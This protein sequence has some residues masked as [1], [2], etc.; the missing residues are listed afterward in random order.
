MKGYLRVVF[1]GVRLVIEN[2]HIS[3]QVCFLPCSSEKYIT[4]QLNLFETMA[5][6]SWL[7]KIEILILVA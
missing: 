3:E 1:S 4:T 5:S 2:H 7:Y 6:F